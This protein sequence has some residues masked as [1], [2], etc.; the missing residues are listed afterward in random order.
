MN[1]YRDAANALVAAI[2][3]ATS[4]RRPYAERRTLAAAETLC[5]RLA[6]QTRED[7]Q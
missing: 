6:E 5:R 4:E 3:R 7:E 2:A 1:P